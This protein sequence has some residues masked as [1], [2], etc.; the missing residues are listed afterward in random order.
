[1]YAGSQHPINAS[2]PELRFMAAVCAGKTDE[3]LEFF[4]EK[5]LFGGEAPAVDAP[6][7]RFEGLEG[8]KT[9]AEGFNARFGAE[10]SFITPVIQTRANGRVVTEAVINL[11]V[12]GEI[13]EVPMFIVGD[14]RTAALL[15]EV[16]LYCHFSFVPGL[17]AYR[18]PIFKAEYLTKGE[19]GLLTGAVREYYDALHNV[20]S[21]DVDRICASF[22]EGCQFG[23]YEPWGRSANHGDAAELRRS[24]ENMS[25]YIPSKVAMRYE[26]IIDDGRT[27]VIEWVHVISRAGREDLG[28]VA[29]SG[30]AAYERGDDG[31]LCAIRISD[32]AG[33]ERTIDWGKLDITL[34]EAQG[35]NFV[36]IYE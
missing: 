27:C 18:A 24:Y 13:E 20:P 16:R 5:K 30:I 10:L 31:L 22:G 12:D 33:F 21:V 9:F 23:G 6:Y 35:V 17:E 1:M 4:R 11:V 26:T 19:P 3:A 2:S 29:M 15:E 14:L 7:G 28:R 25:R 8:I 32:Y 36:E 34:E